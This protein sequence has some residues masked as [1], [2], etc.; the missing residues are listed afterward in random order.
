MLLLHCQTVEEHMQLSFSHIMKH[1]K[2]GQG[3][4]AGK[5]V[6][7]SRNVLLR[8]YPPN[9]GKYILYGIWCD[10]SYHFTE[11]HFR[12][13]SLIYFLVDR[14]KFNEKE[15]SLRTTRE[16]RESIAL[17]GQTVWILFVQMVSN[18]KACFSTTSK[19]EKQI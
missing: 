19:F 2:R 13:H 8:F 15:K 9:A 14:R 17:S 3:P 12:L 7:G 11:Y 6:T 16:R 18:C 5:S 1:W 10:F 4:P